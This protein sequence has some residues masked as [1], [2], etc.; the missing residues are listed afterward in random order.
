MVAAEMACNKR[1][2]TEKIFILFIL[3]GTALSYAPARADQPPPPPSD[4]TVTHFDRYGDGGTCTI[5]SQLNQKRTIA[6]KTKGTESQL[7]WEVPGWHAIF[8]ATGDC[9]TLVIMHTRANLLYLDQRRPDTVV[10]EVFRDGKVSRRVLLGE[11]FPDLTPIER[12]VSH[13]SWLRGFHM[14]QDAFVLETVDGRTVLI[15]FQKHP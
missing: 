4:R 8:F 6:I 11:V 9:R 12:T 1:A 13:W 15:P 14:H 5:H 3:L 10:I 7:L 2:M